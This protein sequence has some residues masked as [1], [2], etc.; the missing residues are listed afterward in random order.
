MSESTLIFI[1]TDP[2][3]IPE[4]EAQWAAA[5]L[6]KSF[7]PKSDEVRA[8]TSDEVEFIVT[9]GNLE[10]ILCPAC[11]ATVDEDWWIEAMNTAYSESKFANLQVILPCCG[12][13]VSLNDL[14]YEWPTGFARF[15]L[16]AHNP[17]TDLDGTFVSRL[18][19]ILGCKLRKIWAHI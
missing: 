7:L 16:E 2:E 14:H 1:P 4:P 12:T 19:Q 18:E 9:G 6:L 17:T 15:R 3:F 10:R 11:G 13:R 8:S 5:E